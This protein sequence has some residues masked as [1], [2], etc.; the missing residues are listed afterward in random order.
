[1]KKIDYTLVANFF[2]TNYRRANDTFVRRI[3]FELA[4][5]GVMTNALVFKINLVVTPTCAHCLEVETI[6]HAVFECSRVINSWR[7]VEI[8]ISKHIDKYNKLSDAEKNM[9]SRCAKP[10]INAMI[11]ATIIYRKRQVIGLPY[12]I[13][14][15]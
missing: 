11:I 15:N 10:T 5:H 14:V 2:R 12:I 6:M 9:W 1:M 13:H 7:Q 3:Q 4:H 8:W